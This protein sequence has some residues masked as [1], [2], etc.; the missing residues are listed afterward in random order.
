[1][2]VI[3]FRRCFLFG[4]LAVLL[5]NAGLTVAADNQ[6]SL[7]QGNWLTEPKDGIIQIGRNAAG[8]YEG[9]I[10][11]GD[12]PDKLDLHNPD[13]SKRDLLLL[14]QLIMRDLKYEAHGAQR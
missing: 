3:R 14:G 6:L 10:V 2:Q 5:F 8:L 11:G 7:I 13:A 1:M 12:A 4:M 9:R